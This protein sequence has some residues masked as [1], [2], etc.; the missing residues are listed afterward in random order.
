MKDVRDNL[1]VALAEA[2]CLAWPIPEGPA[3]PADID[4]EDTRLLR[5]LDGDDLPPDEREQLRQRVQAS[6]WSRQRLAI[7]REALAEVARAEAEQ[8][9]TGVEPAHAEAELAWAGAEPAEAAQ[10]ARA[11]GVAQAA[12]PLRLAF[13]WAADG[14]RYLWGTLEPRSL[15]AVP[16]ATRGVACDPVPGR[17]APPPQVA[18][19]N[20]VE[21]TTFFDFAHRFGEMDVVIQVERIPDERLDVQLSFDRRQAREA[22]L[23]VDLVDRGGR[24]LDSQPVEQGTARFASLAPQPHHICISTPASELGRVQL[25]IL[26]L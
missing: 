1:D 7:L 5:L 3:E 6:A 23:R 12:G 15:V 26:P 11:P 24:L 21:E 14:L 16:V 9:R 2:V 25:D 18:Q 10:G 20:T 13:A 22:H 4:A 8:A 19:A 17:K